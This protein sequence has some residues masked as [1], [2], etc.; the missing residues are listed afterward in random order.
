MHGVVTVIP[1]VGLMT[2]VP[3]PTLL[4]HGTVGGGVKSLSTLLSELHLSLPLAK[5]LT[6]LTASFKF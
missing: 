6:A 3:P 5:S 4:L 2:T 1:A